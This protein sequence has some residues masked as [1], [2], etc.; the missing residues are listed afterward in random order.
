MQ[1]DFHEH[2]RAYREQLEI[3]QVEA[4]KRLGIDHSVLSKYERG[5]LSIPI[6]LLPKF[7]QVYS[8]PTDVFTN[9][10]LDKPLKSKNPGLEARESRARYIKNF[11]EDVISQLIHLKEFRDLSLHILG[12]AS[13]DQERKRLIKNLKTD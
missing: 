5:D 3:T 10:I 13:T 9:M 12:K 2:I 7:A 1:M 11:E 8:I 6:N 4:S